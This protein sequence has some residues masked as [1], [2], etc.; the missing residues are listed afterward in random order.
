MLGNRSRECVPPVQ[1]CDQ[2]SCLLLPLPLAFQLAVPITTIILS[3][4]G[5]S[6]FENFT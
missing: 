2:A 3:A 6:L 4:S 5:T 1:Q